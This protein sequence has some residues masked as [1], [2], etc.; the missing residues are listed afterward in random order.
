[1]A[2]KTTGLQKTYKIEDADGVALYRVVTYGSADGFVKKPTADGA[3]PVGIVDNDE[4]LNISFQAGG[5]QA[6]RDVA[7]QLD[8]IGEVE[9]D[10][11]CA[12]GDRLIVGIGG[13]V[14]KLPA[15]AG[16]YH[17]IGFAEKAGVDGDIIPVRMAYHTA[18]VV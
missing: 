1:M 12:Y 2:G 7:V 4:R 10:G 6:G 5:S 16:T 14:K 8:Q 15:T 9:L 18:T 13:L 11:T 3:I 17:V